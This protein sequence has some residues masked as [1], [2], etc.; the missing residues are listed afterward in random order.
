MSPNPHPQARN[1][2][3]CLYN[4]GNK[5]YFLTLKPSTK[6]KKKERKERKRK[7]QKAVFFYSCVPLTRRGRERERE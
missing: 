6:K 1:I 5:L 4:H 7:Q 2:Y 3:P